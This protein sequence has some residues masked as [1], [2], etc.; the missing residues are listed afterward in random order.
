MLLK[1]YK[2]LFMLGES[3]KQNL[4]TFLA[5]NGRKRAKRIQGNALVHTWF[6]RKT[7]CSST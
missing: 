3:K 4:W 7:T 6:S 1:K 5:Q 2:R